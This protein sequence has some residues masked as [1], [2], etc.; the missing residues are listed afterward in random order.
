MLRGILD[1]YDGSP[2]GEGN[3]NEAHYYRFAIHERHPG[4]L[5]ARRHPSTAKV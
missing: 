5:R 1:V 4:G 2:L 3:G